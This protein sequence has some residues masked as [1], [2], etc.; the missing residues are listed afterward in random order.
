MG[1]MGYAVVGNRDDTS[2]R[3]YVVAAIRRRGDTLTQGSRPGLR[4]S[5]PPGLEEKE[6]ESDG[7]VAIG[8]FIVAIPKRFYPADD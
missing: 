7:S 3:G 1:N 2:S 6:K 5:A 8:D 4:R